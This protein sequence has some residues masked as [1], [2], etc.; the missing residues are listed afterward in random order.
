MTAS[1]EHKQ[2]PPKLSKN[3]QGSNRNAAVEEMGV[4]RYMMRRLVHGG[5]GEADP[6]HAR[7]SRRSG[8]GAVNKA[9]VE[10]NPV[11]TTKAS[12]KRL[13]WGGRHR[14]SSG[15]GGVVDECTV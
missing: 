12:A 11:W 1:H 2:V 7:R 10:L 13:R 5:V 3:L 9:F 6:V 4:L 8:S 14:S 15:S